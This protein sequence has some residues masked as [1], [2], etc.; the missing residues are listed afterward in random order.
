MKV[1]TVEMHGI[2]VTRLL[3]IYST[4]KEAVIAAIE[5]RG[6]ESGNYH[7]FYVFKREVDKPLID[8]EVWA[9]HGENGQV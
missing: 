3:G 9:Y 2:W 5:H 7:S 6:G 4:K 1:Y 8:K